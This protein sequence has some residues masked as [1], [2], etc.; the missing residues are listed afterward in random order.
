M[1]CPTARDAFPE[2]LDSRTPAAALTD[3]RAHLTGCPACQKE[4][5]A[6]S[7]MTAALDAAPPP[8]SA[9]LRRNFHAMLAEEKAA[10]ARTPAPAAVTDHPRRPFIWRSVFST[11]ATAAVLTLGFTVG[12]YSIP[13]AA[14]KDDTTQ[15]ELVALRSQMEQQRDQLAKQSAQ[16]NTMTTLVGYSILQQQ[17][18]PANE[19]L[20]DVLAKAQADNV[21]DRVL[22][23]LLLAVTLDPSAN[24][25][26]RAV[27][28]LYPHA[29]RE[30]VRAGVIAAL[31]RETNPL[32]QLE[33][34]DFVAAA[35]DRN[36][37]PI[38]EKLADDKAANGNVR[39]AAR[40]VLA[41]L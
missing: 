41:K 6:F 4:F 11:L 36:A 16:I 35:Q 32:V 18:N 30:I 15:R 40:L 8:P 29:S 25:R 22:Q 23:D 39:D 10:A 17:Q 13:A 21:S 19:R 14:P 12:R 31:P 34:I 37:A 3:V 2:L 28:A 5:A 9:R 24:V 27:E 33:L 26:L 38:L 7:R 1:N 20:Q